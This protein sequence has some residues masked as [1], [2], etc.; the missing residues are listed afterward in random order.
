MYKSKLHFFI[1]EAYS[2]GLILMG[3]N[4]I[5]FKFIGNNSDFYNTKLN[6]LVRKNQLNEKW[7][8]NRNINFLEYNSKYF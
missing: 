7:L 1:D 6:K 4:F 5:G 3:D 2:N 8:S